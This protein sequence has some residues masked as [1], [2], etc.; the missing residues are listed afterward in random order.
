MKRPALENLDKEELINLVEKLSSRA[1]EKAAELRVSKEKLN[2]AR[3]R[4]IKMK[5]I[6][7]YQRK[8]IIELHH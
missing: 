2:S 8:R 1:E 4:M 5:D 7:Q 3:R 6:L